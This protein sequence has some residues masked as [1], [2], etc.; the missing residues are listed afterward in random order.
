MRDGVKYT[1]TAGLVT[2]IGPG[3]IPEK[4]ATG[5]GKICKAIFRRRFEL[6]MKPSYSPAQFIDLKLS[7]QFHSREIPLML[8]AKISHP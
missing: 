3:F 6:E 4:K 1:G 5:T 8:N 7:T 2:D